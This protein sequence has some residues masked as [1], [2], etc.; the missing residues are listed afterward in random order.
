MK[1]DKYNRIGEINHNNYGNKMVIIKYNNYHNIL[2]KF[3]DGYI[4]KAEYGQFKKGQIKSIYDKSVYN[5]GYIG[6]GKYNTSNKN[7]KPTIQY[8]YWINMMTRCYNDK[9]KENG[10]N[11]SYND[12]YVCEEWHNF[13]NFAEWFDKNYYEINNESMALDKDILVKNN[14]IYSPNTCI[15]VNKRINNLFIK[16]KSARGEYPIGVVYHKRDNE[17]R[18]E[19][20]I[21]DKITGKKRKEKLGSYKNPE[22]AFYKGYK[23]FKEHY[24]KQVANEYKDKI[25]DKLYDAMINYKVEI[26]D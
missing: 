7:G 15:F 22:D 4:T 16:R 11:L 19:C 1:R 18:A 5:I 14:N 13:Q 21:I 26:T 24:I 23:P 25:P 2:V 20:S 8:R 3:E 10:N 12:K 6:K 17:F 9:D